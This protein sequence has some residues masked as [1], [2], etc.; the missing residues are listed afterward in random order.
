MSTVFENDILKDVEKNTRR[1]IKEPDKYKV[2]LHNDNYTTM[3]FVVHILCSIF[4]KTVEDATV[5]ML[6]V[7]NSGLGV[8]GIYTKEIAETKIQQV[9]SE[10]QAAGFPLK[11]SMEKND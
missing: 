2:L 8:C 5:I 3:D 10:A 6:S 11:C 9:H 1:K 4:K 7:H